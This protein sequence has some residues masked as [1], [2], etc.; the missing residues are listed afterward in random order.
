MIEDRKENNAKD[1]EKIKNSQMLNQES[2]KSVTS[3]NMFPE[4]PKKKEKK[5]VF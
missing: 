4:I 5:A 1:W 2:T 3:Y